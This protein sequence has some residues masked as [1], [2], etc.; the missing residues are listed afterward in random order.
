MIDFTFHH[1]GYG[2]TPLL[3]LQLTEA[4]PLWLILPA[5]ALLT[6][7]LL[8][9]LTDRAPVK[10]YASFALRLLAV[11]LLALALTRPTVDRPV[12]R[13]HAVFVLDLS[14][15]VDLADARRALTD[16]DAAIAALNPGDTHTLFT[17]GSTLR[18]S[19]ST[20]A[21]AE[22]LDRWEAGASDDR[23]RAGTDLGAALR[24]AR[25]T[26]PD[27][28]ATRLVLFT[29]ARPTTGDLTDALVQLKD[30]GVQV[31]HEELAGL[32]DPEIAIASL[33]ASPAFAHEGEVVR[34]TASVA[35]NRTG[36]AELRIVHRGVIVSRQD[37]DLVANETQRVDVNV[38]MLTPGRTVWTA[39]IAPK[40]AAESAPES[41]PKSAPEASATPPA[42]GEA[43]PAPDHFTVNNAVS[44]TV[45]VTGRPRILVLHEKA[46]T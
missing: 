11:V 14:A 30:E 9:T 32:S 36:P 26:V 42:A 35:A 13:L 23:F 39:E 24:A 19:E 46:A 25:L 44:T 33:S 18:H 21:V 28:A 38:P 2:P 45:N 41:A 20:Q 10:R 31:Q 5:A 7:G 4:W 34:L 37:V 12:D 8:K 1:A 29:D 6:W 15:S 3:A 17:V 43:R 16:I 22:T 27:D 40:S